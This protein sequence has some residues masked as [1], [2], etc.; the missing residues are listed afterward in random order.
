MPVTRT[1]L[2]DSFLLAGT[3]IRLTLYSSYCPSTRRLLSLRHYRSELPGMECST[4]LFIYRECFFLV[5]IEQRTDYLYIDRCMDRFF[6]H[7]PTEKP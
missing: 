1:I 5:Y 4:P 2:L 3:L 7:V 6:M